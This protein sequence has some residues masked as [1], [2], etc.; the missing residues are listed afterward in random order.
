[1]YDHIPNNF[2]LVQCQE[3]KELFGIRSIYKSIFESASKEAIFPCHKFDAN[4]Q[5]EDT[6][7]IFKSK[8]GLR[9]APY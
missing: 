1:M 8:D 2:T 9:M 3:S 7:T 4:G 6:P 5:L